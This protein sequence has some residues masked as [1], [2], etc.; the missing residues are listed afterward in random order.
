M[1][2]R[3]ADRALD[4]KLWRALQTYLPQGTAPALLAASDFVLKLPGVLLSQ[5]RVSANM[6][7][8]GARQV[9]MVSFQRAFGVVET[10]FQTPGTEQRLSQ[11]TAGFSDPG[12][13]A[14]LFGARGWRRD[15]PPINTTT[16][17]QDAWDA[18]VQRPRAAPEALC[19]HPELAPNRDG[20]LRTG[21][22]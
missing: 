18:S 2:R 21:T 16:Q 22:R 15:S 19:N 17:A 10:L 13:A 11:S 20:C 3:P 12:A 4:K 14:P 9:V 7:K 5:L 1:I 6:M 8:N